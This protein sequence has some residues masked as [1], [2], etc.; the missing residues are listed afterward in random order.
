MA[1]DYRVPLMAKPPT[2]DGK[3]EPAEWANSTGFDGFAFNGAL[4]RRRIRAWVGATKTHLYFA[5]MSQ[6]PDEGQLVA[7][8]ALDTVKIVFDD[9]IE[10]W[11]DPTP[12]S[13][14]GQALQM[15]A[16]AAGRTAYKH[17]GRGNVAEDPTWQGNWKVANGFHAG[18]WHCE[19]EVPIANLPQVAN[20][21]EVTQGAWGIN[22]CRNWKNPWA[23]SSTGGGG[24]TPS[25]RFTFAPDAPAIAHESRADAFLGDINHA[26]ILRNPTTAPI[27]VKAA[28]SLKR[29]VMPEL[30]NSEMIT[31]APG[32]KK[33]VAIKAKDDATR[34]FE[35][36]LSVASPDGK[37]VH[38]Q[39][40]VAWQK[41][42]PWRWTTKKK[43]V[44][45]IDFQ[46]A[47]YPYKN[48]MRVLADVS[49]LPQDARLEGLTCSIRP[50]GRKR[51]VKS[52]TFDAFKDGRQELEFALPH[53]DGQYE[54][55]LTAQGQN[56]PKGELVKEFERTVYEWERK[57]LGTSTTVYPPFTNGTACSSATPTPTAPC[58]PTP[59]PPSCSAKSPAWSPPTARSAWTPPSAKPSASSS[60]PKPC[61]S[62]ST[63]K[64]AGA[65]STTPTTP[66]SPAPVG[67]S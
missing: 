16:N 23:F 46:F 5:L 30:I 40:S 41:G 6:L 44:L 32:E 47:Y 7:D 28:L 24:Y 20:L 56:V 67:P 3:I 1:A 27:A 51:A 63:T 25:D 4:D 60:P 11:I 45:P 34:K 66:T 59:S 21:R 58:T 42:E 53:L 49:N 57:G 52:V 2:I 62:P 61:P 19:V 29:D 31:L 38:Y 26:L 14:H 50:K 43:E 37:T 33:E 48:A 9:S 35:L 8:V 22:L 15:L 39:R 17:H 18:H 13:E 10:V 54:I 36:T 65:T 12:G 55:A 64:A